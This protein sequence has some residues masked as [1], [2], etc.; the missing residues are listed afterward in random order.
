[1]NNGLYPPS[2][3]GSLSSVGTSFTALNVKIKGTGRKLCIV[4]YVARMFKPRNAHT[5]LVRKFTVTALGE[6]NIAGH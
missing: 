6:G 1:M 2:S 5:F 4:L 3:S